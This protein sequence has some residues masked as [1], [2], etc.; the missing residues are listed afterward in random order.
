VLSIVHRDDFAAEPFRA[1]V[2]RTTP[3][4]PKATRPTV[5]ELRAA[6]NV[7]NLFAKLEVLLSVDPQRS[8]AVQ[9]AV[10]ALR[11]ALSTMF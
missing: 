2:A 5:G 4:P 9:T 1:W 8:A 6:Q 3:L 11:A 7:K 10:A